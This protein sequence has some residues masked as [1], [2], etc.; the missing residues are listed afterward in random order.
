MPTDHFWTAV[1]LDFTIVVKGFFIV[2]K[3]VNWNDRLSNT[4]PTSPL[5]SVYD[6]RSIQITRRSVSSNPKLRRLVTRYGRLK[7][8]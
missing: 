1:T 4:E 6:W 8:R 7:R 5:L 3:V 2:F